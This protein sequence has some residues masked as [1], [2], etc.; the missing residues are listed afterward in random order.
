MELGDAWNANAPAAVETPAAAPTVIPPSR[1]LEAGP[2][3][4]TPEP[5]A[6]PSGAQPWTP[7]AAWSQAAAPSELDTLR[8]GIIKGQPGIDPKLAQTL[9]ERILNET[10]APTPQQPAPVAAQPAPAPVPPVTPSEPALT[11]AQQVQA[12]LKQRDAAQGV[13]AAVE[14]VPVTSPVTPVTPVTSPVAAETPNTVTTAPP[15]EPP[16]P[17]HGHNSVELTNR[18]ADLVHKNLPNLSLQKLQQMRAENPGQYRQYF[19][20]IANAVRPEDAA[21]YHPERRIDRDGSVHGPLGRTEGARRC[22]VQRTR[23]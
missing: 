14:N 13:P 7:P 19:E 17:A 10:Q 18:M 4:I 3:V 12:Y 16:H 21:P 9:A 23:I 11:P 5:P 1:Q 15:V 20:Q 8:E 6:D 2:R 22:P